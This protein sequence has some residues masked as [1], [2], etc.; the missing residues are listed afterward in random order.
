MRRTIFDPLCSISYGISVPGTDFGARDRETEFDVLSGLYNQRNRSYLGSF[1]NNIIYSSLYDQYDKSYNLDIQ[2]VRC[3]EEAECSICQERV[4][5]NENMSVLPCNH[6][7]HYNCLV[8]WSDHG[9]NCP[10]CRE[11]IPLIEG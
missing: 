5:L 10:L 1:A 6:V 4:Q 2:P 3:E 7:F 8:K 9:R 11:E